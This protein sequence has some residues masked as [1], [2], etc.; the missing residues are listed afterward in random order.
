[1]SAPLLALC[2]FIYV[3]VAVSYARS[4]QWGMCIAFAAYALA[5]VGF[6]LAEVR[7]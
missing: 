4:G 2:A 1:M 7:R 3:G 5:N 6:I